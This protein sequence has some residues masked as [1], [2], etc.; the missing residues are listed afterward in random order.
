MI[1]DVL[2]C[3]GGTWP[4]VEKAVRRA[5]EHTSVCN[6]TSEQMQ[7]MYHNGSLGVG[8]PAAAPAAVA[9]AGARPKHS[10]STRATQPQHESLSRVLASLA[11]CFVIGC[12]VCYLI[13][14]YLIRMSL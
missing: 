5:V 4:L 2:T 3:G 8:L 13:L 7:Q 10:R 6:A 12:F 14:Y 1:T 11:A 9:P